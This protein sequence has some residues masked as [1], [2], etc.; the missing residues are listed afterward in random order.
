MGC[1]DV[2]VASRD[3]KLRFNFSGSRHHPRHGND[4][5][6]SSSGGPRGGRKLLFQVPRRGAP[7]RFSTALVRPCPIDLPSSSH[8][9]VP[10]ELTN[11]SP[12]LSIMFAPRLGVRGHGGQGLRLRGG[13]RDR[14]RPRSGQSSCDIILSWPSASPPRGLGRRAGEEGRSKP[15]ALP[16]RTRGRCSRRS[17]RGG[18]EGGGRSQAVS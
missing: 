3:T 18:A 15:S 12:L 2:R 9:P 10:A 1:A 6:A 17:G 13:V 16:P 11:L 7:P 14:G 5:R 4:R 8:L